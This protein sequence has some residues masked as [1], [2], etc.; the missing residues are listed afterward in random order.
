MLA[1]HEAV[2]RLRR[3]NACRLNAD[4]AGTVRR[5]HVATPVLAGRQ[6][7]IV[8]AEFRNVATNERHLQ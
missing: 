3:V 4:E 6:L 1:H 7:D 8:K 5:T 2:R